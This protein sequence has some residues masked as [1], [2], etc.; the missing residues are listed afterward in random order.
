LSS[1]LLRFLTHT[2]NF[3][4]FS[5]MSSFLLP[6]FFLP[7]FPIHHPSLRRISCGS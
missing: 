4:P 5:R 3:F 2:S 1:L 7:F 6:F